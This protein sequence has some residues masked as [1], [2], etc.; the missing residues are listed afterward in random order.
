MISPVER[1]RRPPALRRC[2]LFLP[3]AERAQ[4]LAAPAAGADVLIQELEDFTPPERRPEARAMAPEIYA[5]WR[6]AGV[7]AGVRVNPLETEGRVDLAAV[8]R[9]R[10]DI[11]LM[12][13]VAE[14][15]QVVALA[16]AVLSEEYA[17]GI[18]SGSTELVP[19]IE[20]ARGL[21]QAFAIATASPRVTAVLGS[22]E[23]MAADLGAP[24]TRGAQELAYVRQRL[25]VECVAAGVVSVD[26][27]YTFADVEGCAADARLARAMGYGAKSA[28]NPAHVAAINAAMTPSAEEIRRA[29]A[30][31][32]AFEAARVKGIDRVDVD[33]LIVE[34]PTYMS[35]RR[36]VA[37]AEALGVVLR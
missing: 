19:N 15:R 25:H 30:M 12:S 4:L 35:A 37:R 8:M 5:A 18:P 7:L 17:N 31:I 9:G 29:R 16:E 14:R 21:I 28:V 20:S 23:D 6:S 36:L 3:G 26:C 13:K 1:A 10:P 24:R 33:G 32:A 34:I 27:P 11:V 2:W 22:T